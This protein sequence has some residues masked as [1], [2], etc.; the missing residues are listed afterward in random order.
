MRQ[1]GIVDLL[2]NRMFKVLYYDKTYH[3]KMFQAVLDMLSLYCY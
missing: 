2:I 1:V 3:K